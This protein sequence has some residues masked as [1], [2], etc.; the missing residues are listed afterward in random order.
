MK[1]SARELLL[2]AEQ[3]Q[4]GLDNFYHGPSDEAISTAGRLNW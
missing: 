4:N 1:E 2:F 3:G